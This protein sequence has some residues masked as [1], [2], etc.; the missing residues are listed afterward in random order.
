MISVN[1]EDDEGFVVGGSPLY[2]MVLQSNG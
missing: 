2:T 1:E